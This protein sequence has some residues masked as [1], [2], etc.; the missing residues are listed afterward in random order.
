MHPRWLAVLLAIIFLGF[1]AAAQGQAE[2]AS[3]TVSAV[4]QS[5]Q[6]NASSVKVVRF[7][8]PYQE[9]PSLRIEISQQYCPIKVLAIRRNC[10]TGRK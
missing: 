5:P 9:A 2:P 8:R 4:A 10:L 6:D 7:E 1:R 3:A